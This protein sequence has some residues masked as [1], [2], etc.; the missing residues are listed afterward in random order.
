MSRSGHGKLGAFLKEATM[1]S[2]MRP[3]LGFTL[4]SLALTSGCAEWKAALEDALDGQE[5]AGK[6][7]GTGSAGAPGTDPGTSLTCDA[8]PNADGIVCKRCVD[9]S[10]VVVREDCPPSSGSGS[11]GS[12]GSNGGSRIKIDGGGGPSGVKEAAAREKDGAG[13]GAPPEPG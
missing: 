9:A 1:P 3:L 8:V 13:P 5:G 7:V 2:L 12:G 11:G 4:L 6:G 10:G